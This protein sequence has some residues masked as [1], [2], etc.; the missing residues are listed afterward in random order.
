MASLN[1]SNQAQKHFFKKDKVKGQFFTPPEVADFI[2]SLAAKYVSSQEKT[3]CDPACGDGVFLSSLLKHGF[4]PFG[5]DI[6]EDILNSLPNGIK[7]FASKG[8][9]LLLNEDRKF[10]LVVGNPPF[11]AKYGRVR[12]EI[13][14]NFDLGR[15]PSQ[16]IEILFL[17]KFVR[18]CKDGGVIGIILPHGIF[19]DTRLSYVREFIKSHLMIIA[20]VSLPRNIFKGRESRT[21]SKTCI[22]LAKKERKSFP[23]EVLFASIMSP[24]ELATNDIKR[25]TFAFPEEFL[26]PEF[27]L[28][29][30]PLLENLPKLKQF[31]IEIIQ[32]KAKYGEERKFSP[33]GIPFISAKVVTPLGIDFSRDKKFVQQGSSMDCEKAYTKVGDVLFV[34][35]GVGCIGRTA[36]V[37]NENEVG[38]ADDWIYIIRI[39]D[40]RLSPYFLALWLQTTFV[41]A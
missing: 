18:L 39:K 29:R 34:R 25:K 1:I 32:G 38:I 26:Y 2:V 36:V 35:V 7:K 4:L 21:S 15:G 9:G 22:L 14:K 37:T 19:S 30:N 5:V 16:A 3:A 8:D 40:N 23:Q 31:N 27:Y 11:S 28:Q 13:L 20:I 24:E 33:Q 12:G 41:Q 6:D 10:A 17:E